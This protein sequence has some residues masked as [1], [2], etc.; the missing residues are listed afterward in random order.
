MNNIH[1]SV[2]MFNPERITIGKNVRIDCFCVLSA[3]D[4]GIEIGDNVHIA[5]GSQIFGHS[6]KVKIGSFSGLSAR[7]TIFTASDDF[8]EGY[9]AGPTIPD[10]YRKITKGPVI[11]EEHAL[12]GCGAIILP[13]VTLGKGCS[14][15]AMTLVKKDVKPYRV[16][17]GHDQKT[18]AIK[19]SELLES[20]KQAFQDENL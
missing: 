13:G 16:V 17:V 10:K 18:I 2:I 12:I 7:V 3:G 14:V 6:A 8:I 20:L 9:L 11:I 15:G 4:E 1:S 19:D 5:S